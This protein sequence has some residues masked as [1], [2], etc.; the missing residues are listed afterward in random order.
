MAYQVAGETYGSKTALQREWRL[1]V[2]RYPAPSAKLR[3]KRKPNLGD[4]DQPVSVTSVAVSEVDRA[5]FV[6]AAFVSATHR[7]LLFGAV[8]HSGVTHGPG[9][10][11]ERC[12]QAT[13]VFVDSAATSFKSGALRFGVRAL[14]AGVCRHLAARRCVF[15]RCVGTPNKF[16]SVSGKVGDDPVKQRKL[17]VLG[18]LR[19]AVQC[20]IDA[21]R[22]SRKTLS[23][24]A[25]SAKYEPY[26]CDLCSKSCRGK[27]NHVDHGTGEHSFKAIVA[28]FQTDVLRRPAEPADCQGA[29]AK[30]TRSKWRKFH[31]AAAKLSLTCAACNLRNK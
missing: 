14:P 13:A 11:L 1:R 8:L 9:A 27:E 23:A 17:C 20:Q 25:N 15:F 12:Q 10:C 19:Q 30:E 29:E 22:R 18:W 7:S 16:R 4:I 24:D 2:Q 28:R 21:Y 26:R 3:V 5:W 31:R 6:A